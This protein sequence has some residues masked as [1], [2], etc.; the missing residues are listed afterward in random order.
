V[1]R[2]INVARSWF[3]KAAALNNTEAKENL[4][5]L[6]EVALLDGAPSRCKTNVLRADVCN[7][8]QI[9]REFRL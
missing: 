1:Q 7:T 3:D 5:R 2:N 9:V 6:E 8:S 4:N